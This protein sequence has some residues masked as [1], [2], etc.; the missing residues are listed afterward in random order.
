MRVVSCCIH[1]RIIR[2]WTGWQVDTDEGR[3]QLPSKGSVDTSS[4]EV[5]QQKSSTTR[6]HVLDFCCHLG[7][8]MFSAVLGSELLSLGA[9]RVHPIAVAVLSGMERLPAF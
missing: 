2:H 9:L 3:G 8:G 1:I 5:G 4:A 6:C 7:N